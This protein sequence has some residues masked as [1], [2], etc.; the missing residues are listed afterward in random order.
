MMEF[1]QMNKFISLT[2]TIEKKKNSMNIDDA[3]DKLNSIFNIF[4]S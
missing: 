2:K 3:Y 4:L 1:F